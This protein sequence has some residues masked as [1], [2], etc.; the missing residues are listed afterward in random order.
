MFERS[1]PSI[2]MQTAA[3]VGEKRWK[4]SVKEKR[5]RG[6]T[7]AMA[8]GFQIYSTSFGIYRSENYL[9]SSNHV[10]RRNDMKKLQYL[11]KLAFLFH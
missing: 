1:K 10:Y 3:V 6:K 4:A 9:F 11:N 2:H 5:K 7:E 8:V